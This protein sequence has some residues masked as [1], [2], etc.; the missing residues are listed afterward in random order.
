MT[1]D[2]TYRDVGATARPDLLDNPPRGFRPMVRKAQ[3]GHGEATFACAAH[4]TMRFGIQRRAGLRVMRGVGLAN[5]DVPLRE[6][7]IALLRLA[8]P[9]AVAPIAVQIVSVVDEPRRRGFVYG[10]RRGHP[11]S[12]E[13]SFVVEWRDDD[14]VWLEIRAFSRPAHPVLW[15]GYPL[16]RLLQEIYTRRYLRVLADP[17]RTGE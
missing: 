3:I 13:E 8:G 10:T 12:G 11:E 17:A 5:G 9:L 16:L 15:L 7:D 1:D 2:L 6:G 4:E 14:S